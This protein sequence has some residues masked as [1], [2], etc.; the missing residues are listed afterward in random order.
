M[1]SQIFKKEI[2][3][4]IFTNF[5]DK[6]C[7]KTNNI[8]KFDKISFKK[9]QLNGTINELIEE[10]EPYYHESKKFYL[11]RN[12]NYNYFITIIRQICKS[13]KITYTSKIFY[14]KSKYEII[15]NIHID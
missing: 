11:T 7:V 15:Y 13:L 5:L 3:I 12:I 4:E 9:C 10:I 2:P 8:Y 1:T 14:D 6:S